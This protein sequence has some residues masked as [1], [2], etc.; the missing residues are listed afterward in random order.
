M[1]EGPFCQICAHLISLRPIFFIFIGYLRMEVGERGFEHTPWTPSESATTY[2]CTVFIHSDSFNENKK[3]HFIWVFTV[4]TEI[5]NK[6]GNLKGSKINYTCLDKVVHMWKQ[7]QT[8]IL[9]IYNKTC[10]KRPLKQNTKIIAECSPLQVKSIIKLP[11][12]IKTFVLSILVA[13]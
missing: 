8:C 7:I 6:K 13:A 4:F 1:P 5:L 12:S 2:Y 11:F 9:F 3:T 10:L